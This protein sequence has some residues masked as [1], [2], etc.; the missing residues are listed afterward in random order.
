MAVVHAAGA[1]LIRHRVDSGRSRE[2]LPAQ[3]AGR[4]GHPV[5]K[6]GPAQR[7]HRIVACSRSLEGIAA[8]AFLP[9][10][11]PGLPG[12]ADLVFDPVVVRLEFV[13][14]EG[15]VLDGR[16]GRQPR[17]SVA[18][19]RLADDLE[20][21][22][23]ETPA[24]GPVVQGGAADRVHHRMAA[25]LYRRVGA[26]ASQRRHLAVALAHR[27]GP[28]ADVVA[29]L[30]GCEVPFRQPAAGLDPDDV[31]SRVGERQR[32]HA[33]GGAEPHDHDVGSG[34]PSRHGA[35]P[36]FVRGPPLSRNCPSRTPNG[37]WAPARLLR[38]ESAG[39]G[40]PR[41]ARRDSES[42]PSR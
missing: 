20:I 17:P 26:G 21:P 39:R 37:G 34:Q 24:L 32:G 10:H 31:E 33:S 15:P 18:P 5:Q 23:V 27:E 6:T 11:V 2:R 1:S 13:V 30:V 7:R 25:A 22:R 12:D 28:V 40:T 4:V 16:A 19:R 8:S 42:D 9:L 14:P 41:C 29:N 38:D 36:S 3:R 35:S